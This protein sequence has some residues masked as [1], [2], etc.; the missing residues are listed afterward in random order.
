MKVLLIGGTGTISSAITELLI[1]SGWEVYLLNR[2]NRELPK[3]AKQLVADIG[4]ETGV[5]HA[6]KGMQFD[7]VA[8]FRAFT[9]VDVERDIRVFQGITS[10]YMFIS[11]A[12]AYQKPARSPYITESTPLVNPYWQYSRDKAASE[13]ILM[14]HHRNDGFPVTIVRPSHTYNRESLPVAIHGNKGSWQVIKRMLEGK[15][16]LIHGDGSSLWTLTHSRDFAAGFVGLMGNIHAIGHAVHITSDESLTWNQVYESVANALGVKHHPFYAPSDLIAEAG[17]AY[18]YDFEGALLGDKAATVIFDNSKLKRLVPGFAAKTRFD[19][20]VRE[21]VEYYLN[22][23]EKQIEDPEF[24]RFCN[25]MFEAMQIARN[26][27]K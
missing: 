18:G 23:R 7:V 27:L 26:S 12:S 6:V 14:S 24:D 25:K 4:D 1:E 19:V 15:P 8:N 16:V 11:S 2:G 17:K 9:P 13:E 22:H 20:G 3:G 10:Q 5:S 21:S